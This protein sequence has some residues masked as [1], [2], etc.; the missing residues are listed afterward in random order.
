MLRV[1]QYTVVQECESLPPELFGM[2]LV[3]LR[4]KEV[5]IEGSDVGGFVGRRSGWWETSGWVDR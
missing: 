4:A 5:L 2:F 3:F 1:V